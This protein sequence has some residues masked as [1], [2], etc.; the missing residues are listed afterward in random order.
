[1]KADK[2]KEKQGDMKRQGV[3]SRYWPL[4]KYRRTLG[5]VGEKGVYLLP[6]NESQLKFRS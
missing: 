1:M 6:Q 5:H 3:R 2:A 4:G